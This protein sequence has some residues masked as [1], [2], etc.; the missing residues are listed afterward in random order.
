VYVAKSRILAQV[1]A[2]IQQLQEA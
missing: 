1:K 2:Q